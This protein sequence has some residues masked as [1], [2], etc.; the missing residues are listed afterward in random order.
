MPDIQLTLDTDERFIVDRSLSS[1][2]QALT[3]YRDQMQSVNPGYTGSDEIIARATALRAR[4][5]AL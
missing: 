4:L 2:I 5:G 1:F 3:T